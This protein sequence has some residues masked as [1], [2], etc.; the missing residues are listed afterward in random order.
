MSEGVS[1]VEIESVEFWKS[2]YGDSS[3]TEF[4]FSKAD[5]YSL[6]DNS[7]I[8]MRNQI[9]EDG[10][11]QTDTVIAKAEILKLRM[12]V[13]ALHRH[14]VMPLFVSVYDEFWGLL[15]KLREIFSPILLDGYRLVPDFWVWYVGI[16]EHETGWKPHRDGNLEPGSIRDDGTPRLCTAWI[17]LT[18]V[19]TDNSCMYVLP[20][21]YD[22]VFQDFIRR[23]MGLKGVANAMS[24]PMPLNRIRALP[25][26]AGAILGWD[27]N[28][29]HWGSGS[30][31]WASDPRISIGVYYEA[32]DS[33]PYGVEFDEKGRNYIDY[34][35]SNC[36]L[37]FENRLT[38]IA[39]ILTAYI[40]KFDI[41][42]ELD[43]F[44]TDSVREFHLA[45][46]K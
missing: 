5:K 31:K 44:L 32:E 3:I 38:I 20:R 16:G 46:S 27:T 17:P 15:Y 28:L 10:Y 36:K 34:E 21:K 12:I 43:P 26:D 19:T 30:S 33:P 14:G 41:Q 8:R 1:R 25:V 42:G 37:T 4:P 11:F 40:G 9:I 23:R 6:D 13:E 29:L 2:L 22:A 24:I 39:N 18:D 7:K 45:W 35:N